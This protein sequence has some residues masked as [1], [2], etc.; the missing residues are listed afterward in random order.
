MVSEVLVHGHLARLI[1]A[2]GESE[3]DSRTVWWRNVVHRKLVSKEGGK[4]R[5]KANPFI[6]KP[7]PPNPLRNGSLSLNQPRALMMQRL[8]F[9]TL[10]YQGASS[11][12]GHFKGYTL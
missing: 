5:G 2:C 4:R 3:H 1:L 11:Q 10:F 9:Q 6:T 12:P 7:L 8:H